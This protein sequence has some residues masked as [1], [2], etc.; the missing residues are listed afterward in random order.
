MSTPKTTP[1]TLKRIVENLG[2]IPNKGFE[3]DIPKMT[4]EQKSKLMEMASMFETF[5]ENLGQEEKISESAKALGEFAKL[6]ESYALN[7]SGDWFQQ[8]IV[9]KDMKSMKGKVQEYQKCAQECYA[10]MQQLGVLY[11]DIRHVAGRYYD[12]K[13]I[14]EQMGFDQPQQQSPGGGQPIQEAPPSPVHNIEDNPS[15]T[16][17]K[18]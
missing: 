13:K 9:K 2:R 3:E 10:R 17:P 14:Q 7:E 6:A 12:L 5:G 8:E 15:L 1:F 11:E 16:P 4:S 18:W